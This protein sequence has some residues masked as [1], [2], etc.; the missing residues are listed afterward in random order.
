MMKTFQNIV[1]KAKYGNNLGVHGVLR[2]CCWCGNHNFSWAS[3]VFQAL[4]SN[5]GL[6]N[7]NNDKAES[8]SE[9]NRFV[10]E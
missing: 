6:I 3:M 10:D 7:I 2:F 8:K 4:G 5:L 1:T 9:G